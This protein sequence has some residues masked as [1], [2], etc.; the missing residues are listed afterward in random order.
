MEWWEKEELFDTKYRNG[1]V[2]FN[3]GKYIPQKL[4]NAVEGWDT[5]SDGYWVYLSEGYHVDTD[6]I[7]HCYTIMDILE[8]LKRIEKA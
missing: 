6:R 4:Y 8:D 2:C 5:D 3:L 1:T 7:I